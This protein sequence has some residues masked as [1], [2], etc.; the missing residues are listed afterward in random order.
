MGEVYRAD[1]LKLGETVALK[2]LPEAMERDPV[3]Y[4]RFLREVRLARG[5]THPNVCRVH[6][7]DEVDG[8]PFLSMEYV[9]GEDLASLLRRIGRLPR[10]KAIDLGR[11]IC[12]GLAAAHAEGVLHRDLKPA[13]VLIDGRGRAKI[14]DF[15]LALPADAAAEEAGGTPA[16]A[17]PE[18]LEGGPSTTRS[19]VFSLGL[20]LYELFTGE[21][22][23]PAGSREEL[24]RQYES[25]S[26]SSPS[27]L[28]EGLDP[29]AERAILRCL[30]RDPAERPASAREVA[31]ALPGGDPLEAAAAAGE[32]PPPELVVAAGSKEALA[33]WRAWGLLALLGVALAAAVALAPRSD[34]FRL[35]SMPYPPE[36]LAV[37]A[38]EMLADLGYEPTRPHSAYG[39]LAWD[40]P[41][42]VAG[43]IDRLELGRPPR[44]WYRQAEGPLLPP[45]GHRRSLLLPDPAD[46]GRGSD[47][48]ALVLSA[49]GHLLKLLAGWR[50]APAESSE[51]EGSWWDPL[52]AAA[53]ID[54][55]DLRRVEP[56]GLLP[57]AAE[58]SV[59]WLTGEGVRIE[60]AAAGGAPLGFVI[61][62][63]EEH[64]T[65]IDFPPGRAIFLGVLVLTG[66]VATVLFARRNLRLGRGDSRAGGRL[67]LVVFGADFLALCLT[68]PP[69]LFSWPHLLLAV[70]LS[71]GGAL[72][73]GLLYLAVEPSSRR[74]WPRLLI[75]WI[76]L[77]RGRF[78]DPLVG[79]HVLYGVGLG[80]VAALLWM[81]RPVV[82]EWTGQ[83]WRLYAGFVEAEALRGLTAAVAGL[84]FHL[85][86]SIDRLFLPFLI[87][88]VLLRAV[89]RRTR[90]ATWALVVVVLAYYGVGG[91]SSVE[92]FA[93]LLIAGVGLIALFR[94]GLLTVV[95]FWTVYRWL[96][97]Y[98]L[99]ANP[100]A[101]YFDRSLLAVGAVAALGLWGFWASSR[102]GRSLLTDE[103][104][105]S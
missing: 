11:E 81:L 51:T 49:D 62:P 83:T 14:T 4:Q 43:A 21:R 36:V 55:T 78:G 33:P 31:A 13:N 94:I 19:D 38:R 86:N 80:C 89:L 45:I 8:R 87:V 70:I 76:R 61:A 57:V 50:A 42:E 10:E 67:G 29:A 32:T 99:T 54:E 40:E 59:A 69:I 17:S 79:R 58:R 60:A 73:L 12:L 1:D 30:E 16:Y 25:S 18:Q 98:P 22:P 15:G 5:V 90:V 52:L 72:L 104:A 77:L 28:V 37:K 96:L 48:V 103:L 74:H 39:F 84:F 88:L 56:V 24:S 95:V 34:A 85:T 53:G 100:E 44:F 66:L 101:W 91:V 7:V 20:V 27:S 26:P 3:W 75:S 64:Q 102:G 35:A 71:A 9:G 2:F 46:E 63:E 68:S 92:T 82:A 97:N 105:D 65:S 41:V 6:D 23:F 93:A 47:A